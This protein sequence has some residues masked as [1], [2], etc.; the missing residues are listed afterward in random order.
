MLRLTLQLGV[1]QLSDRL[2]KAF[3][4]GA[5]D[6]QTPLTTRALQQQDKHLSSA[7]VLRQWDF[8]PLCGHSH[9]LFPRWATLEAMM[10]GD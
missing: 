9:R 8:Q 2:R 10:A 6:C 7:R 5:N 4:N 1:Q 3:H